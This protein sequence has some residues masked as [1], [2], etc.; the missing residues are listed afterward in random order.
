ML[1]TTGKSPGAASRRIAGILSLSI[2]LSR[3]ENRGSRSLSSLISRAAK[4]RFA[5]LCTV[6]KEQG[7]PAT[8]AF[9]SLDGNEWLSPKIKIEK[10][11]FISKQQKLPQAG[12]LSI[13]GSKKAV[14]QK[15]ISPVSTDGDV[16][17]T[18]NAG[19]KSISFYI[20]R[21]KMLSLGVSYEK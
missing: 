8:I 2:P 12:R 14:L 6:Y 9:L 5:R 7:N 15:L 10:V 3:S 21:K 17:S 1:V 16:Q 4:S 20:R 19:A 18:I 13:K 11:I